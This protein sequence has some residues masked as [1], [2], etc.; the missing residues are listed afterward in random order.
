MEERYQFARH[1]LKG[2]LDFTVLCDVFG[3]ST[4]TGYKWVHRFEE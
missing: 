3:I 4:K 2:E 1:A